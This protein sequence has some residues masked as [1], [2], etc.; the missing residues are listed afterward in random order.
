MHKLCFIIFNIFVGASRK[1]AHA[2]LVP[3]YIHIYLIIFFVCITLCYVI[4]TIAHVYICMDISGNKLLTYLLTYLLTIYDHMAFA[5]FYGLMVYFTTFCTIFNI[6]SY[7]NDWG[8]GLCG[9]NIPI[10]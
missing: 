9:E 5:N 8:G 2:I 3:H 6:L 7:S 10:Y 4:V 1:T